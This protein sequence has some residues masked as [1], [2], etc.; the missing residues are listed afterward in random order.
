MSSIL[1]MTLADAAVVRNGQTAKPP[2][3]DLLP[4]DIVKIFVGN[5]VP[6]G[7][8]LLSASG[9]LHF[10]RSLLTGEAEEVAGTTGLTDTSYLETR[11]IALMGS[12]SPTAMQLTSLS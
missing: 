7:M 2:S 12:L 4:G 6:A 10:D 5:K 9:D 1:D 3:I 8:R 11:S